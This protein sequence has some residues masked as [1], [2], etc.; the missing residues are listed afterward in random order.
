MNG[1]FESDVEGSVRA[2]GRQFRIPT[3]RLANLKTF[4]VLGATSPISME[5]G[6]DGC[7]YLAEFTGFWGPAP[8]SNVS[9][10]C[11]SNEATAAPEATTTTTSR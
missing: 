7:L 9:R 11:W 4:D 1:V 6:P 5:L 8:G 2:D 10:Y 3:K